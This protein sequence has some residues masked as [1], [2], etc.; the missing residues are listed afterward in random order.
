MKKMISLTSVLLAVI[1][2]TTAAFTDVNRFVGHWENVESKET[3][4]ILTIDITREGDKIAVQPQGNCKPTPCIWKKSDAVI[5]TTD[6]ESDLL[7]KATTLSAIFNP[8]FAEKIV[9]LRIIEGNK[10][11]AEIYTRFTDRSKRANTFITHT[12]V[13]K[14]NK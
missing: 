4:G 8:G 10:L 1:L 9:T 5:Y 6:V 13:L 11:E 12:F 14:E 7:S 3:R 2:T